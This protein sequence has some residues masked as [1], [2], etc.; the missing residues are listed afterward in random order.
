VDDKGNKVFQNALELGVTHSEFATSANVVKHESSGD[1]EESLWIAHA[2]NNAKDNDAID[3]R[4]K[5]STLYDQLTDKT[6]STTPAEARM[7]LS[8]SNNT[9]IARNARV[10][11]IDVLTGGAV[12]WDGDDF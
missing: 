11:V 5:N 4:R 9:T 8:T 12:L 6:Y 7:P 10:A 2:T 3:W 1:K